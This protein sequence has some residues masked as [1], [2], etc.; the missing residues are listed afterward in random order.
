MKFIE[1]NTEF[2]VSLILKALLTRKYK[3]KKSNLGYLE[4]LKYVKFVKNMIL[5]LFKVLP[6]QF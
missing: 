5:N 4:S 2:A 1:L 3:T 6:I